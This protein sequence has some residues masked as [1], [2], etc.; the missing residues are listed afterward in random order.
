MGNKMV[1]GKCGGMFQARGFKM[2]E[3]FC[4]GEKIDET[5]KIDGNESIKKCHV[6]GVKSVP[7]DIVRIDEYSNS[8]P[9]T[10]KKILN[11]GYTHMCTKCGEVL[12]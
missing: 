7:A 6:C 1:C 5:K 2:H 8:H 10:V 9:N 3:T 11:A 12:K 4:K